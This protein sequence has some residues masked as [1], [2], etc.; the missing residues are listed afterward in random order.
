MIS[1]MIRLHSI[2]EV[3]A[4]VH[5]AH[6]L[7]FS[8]DLVSGGYVVDARSIMGVLSMDLGKS[9]E[10]RLYTEDKDA[11]ARMVGQFLA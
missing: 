9:L 3:S 5:A 1:Q 4:F 2:E 10:L 7:P 6:Q 8:A 11:A